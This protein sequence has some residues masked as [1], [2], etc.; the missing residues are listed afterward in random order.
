MKFIES[1][2]EQNN[3]FK[4]NSEILHQ[5]ESLGLPNFKT[6]LWKNTPLPRNI[7]DY[8]IASHNSDRNLPLSISD[9]FVEPNAEYYK[10]ENGYCQQLKNQ[11]FENQQIENKTD[12]CFFAKDIFYLLNKSIGNIANQFVFNHKNE[13]QIVRFDYISDT[14]NLELI[15]LQ[16]I[17]VLEE[18]ANAEIFLNF[19]GNDNTIQNNIFTIIQSPNSHLKINILSNNKDSQ[20][21][22]NFRIIINNNADLTINNV[23]MKGTFIRNNIQ[24]DI[25]GS[26]A[27]VIANCFYFVNEMNV[28][29]NHIL[30]NHNAPN[31]YSNQFYKGIIGEEGRGIFDGKIYVK[32][33]AQKTDAY[34]TNRNILTSDDAR[35][36]TKPALEIYADDV[37]CSHGATSGFLQEEEIFYLMSRGIDKENSQ[38]LLLKAFANDVIEKISNENYRE[39]L[40]NQ[41]EKILD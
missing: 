19:I 14:A 29:D 8:S 35:I 40:G 32:K 41:I 37:K 25:N 7:Y 15:N 21:I 24:V 13:N 20:I 12:E 5:A 34:Q 22:N 31:S 36:F 18:S 6:E 9:V 30:M 33:D 1:L 23:S 16:N 2:K 38:K 3:N 4:I 26:N 28:A 10:F 17:F 27:E 11:Q 39:W